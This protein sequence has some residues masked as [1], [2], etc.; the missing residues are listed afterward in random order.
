[1]LS[2]IESLWSLVYS[3]LLDLLYFPLKFVAKFV[4]IKKGEFVDPLYFDDD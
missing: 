3:I 4:I 2:N 1:M